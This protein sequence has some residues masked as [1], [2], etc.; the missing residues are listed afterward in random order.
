MHSPDDWAS[1]VHLIERVVGED[2]LLPSVVNGVRTM[3]REVAVLPAADVSGH[4]RA[5]L[6]AATRAVAARRGPTEAELSFVSELGT[7]RALQG[8][9]IE[10][11]LSAIHVAERAIWS[12]ARETAAEEGVSAGLLLDA[13]ELY[14]DWSE[15]VRARLIT[16]HRMTE[17]ARALPAANR[18]AALLRRL[19]AGGSAA[20][21]AATE[22]GLTGTDGLWV[23]LA[24]PGDTLPATT[25]DRTPGD[26]APGDRAS[27]DRTPGDRAPALLALVDG[28]LTGVL[29]RAPG[30]A[31]VPGGSVAGVAGPAGPEE[32]AAARRLALAALTA[33]E[34]AGRTGVVHIADVASLAAVLDR[35]DLSSALADHHRPALAALGGNARAVARA[36][37]TWLEADRDITAAAAALFVHPNTI[38]NRVQR[39]TQV[40][41]IDPHTTFGGVDAW[42]LCRTWLAQP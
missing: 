8:V 9:P 11:V 17:V 2:D 37:G 38:R 4:T 28:L 5:L 19:L 41:G 10:A 33:A 20:A 15:A 12:R 6:A 16:A 24:R 13:R 22:A 1:M 42:W 3:V 27:S 31:P 18:D 30:S 25:G 23:L 36:V 21:L 32:L 39:F 14:D 7:A 29:T 35:A 34:A 40:T 26:R